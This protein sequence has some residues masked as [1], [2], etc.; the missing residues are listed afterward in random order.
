ML[1]WA[2]LRDPHDFYADPESD[3]HFDADM[4]TYTAFYFDADPDYDPIPHLT[5]GNLRQLN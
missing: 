5:D 4:D 1:T 2:G 3:F